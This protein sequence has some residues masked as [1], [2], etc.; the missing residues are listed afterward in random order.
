VTPLED[1]R[2][3]VE[4]AA[5]ELRNGE[6]SARPTL[7]RPKQAGFGDYSTN[8]AMLLAPALKAP[9]REIAERLGAALR[10]RLG[11]RVERIEVAGPGFLNVFL[12]DGWHT[13][14]AAHMLAA[15]PDYGGGTAAQP[16]R[17]LIEFVSA[18]PTGPL[19]AAS[20]R[21]AAYGDALARLLEFAGNEV[22]REYYFNDAGSQ[23]R[24]L[25]E[26]IRARARGEQPP[27]DGYQGDYVTE[28]AAEIPEAAE[29]DPEALA[30]RGGELMIE[31][32]KETLDRYGVTFD[33]WFSERTLH[34]GDPSAI[35]RGLAQLAEAG[36]SFEA[37]GALWLR[38]TAFGEDQDR[39]L[40]RGTGAPTYFAADV[41]Y[42]ENKLE[43]GFERLITP[44]G[45]DHHGYVRRFKAA[46]S[47]LGADPDRLEI[48]LLQFVHVVE[49]G[50]RAS[51]SKRR[52][53]IITLDELVEKIGVDAAR[54]FMLQRSHD[55]TVDLDLDLAREQSSE[56]PVYYVQYAHARIASV[57]RKAGEARV[58]AALEASWEGLALDPA[59]RELVKK[60]VSFPGEA[61]E[62]ADR[63]APH[64]ITAY[65]LELAQTFTAFY[66]DCRV[67]G[68]EPEAL[69]SFRLA[70]CVIS[71]RTIARSLDLLGV[72][73][74]DT[75]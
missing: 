38:T 43:R 61:A 48:P 1:L 68:A 16:E 6:P 21:H 29:G 57:L 70:L 11:E 60:L 46:M 65:A 24:K 42:I 19:T 40:R 59:E 15:G 49:G 44:L 50:K 45:A 17:V 12:A 8:A 35:E 73:A 20:G 10:E 30:E 69:E 63:R 2:S 13:A 74:P 37:D 31:R 62:A 51:M 55:T 18:N 7:E 64:R 41:A 52:G 32:I 33:T 72:S 71:R 56:N 36:H 47:A 14:A 54:Y 9:P 53:D 25:G 27:E 4:A 66:R 5:A 34:Q 28:L 58:A 67:V 26:S 23:L 39:V 3:A 22:G 75:M